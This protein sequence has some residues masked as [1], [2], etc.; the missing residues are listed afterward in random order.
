[1]GYI[2]P[3]P[4]ELLDFTAKCLE[5]N[6]VKIDWS[7]ASENN[8]S[9]FEVRKSIDGYTWNTINTIP[10]AGNSTELLEYS[11]LDREVS[12][13]NVY[14][15]L[16]QVDIDGKS[17]LFDVVTS[18]CIENETTN[19]LI[20]FPNPSST[21]FYVDFNSENIEGE[22]ILSITDSRGVLVCSQNVKIEKGNNFYTVGET[23]EIDGVYYINLQS[24][25]FKSNVVKHI[26]K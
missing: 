18:N 23:N 25:Q 8:S 5:D 24:D 21:E 7:T 12:L 22:G 1:M 26:I 14:Y 10:A 2:S 17:E 4:V 6:T 19:L 20:T 16:N 11:I 15:R 3:L 13:N 9:Y